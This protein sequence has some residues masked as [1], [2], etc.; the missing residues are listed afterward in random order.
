MKTK[1]CRRRHRHIRHQWQ[2]LRL[3]GDYF[4]VLTQRLLGGKITGNNEVGD[5]EHH[6]LETII[7]VKGC[8]SPGFFRVF[9]IQMENLKAISGTFPFNYCLYALWYYCS[10]QRKKVT[11]RYR[12]KWQ[13]ELSRKSR[14]EKDLDR[15]LAQKTHIVYLV[16]LAVIEALAR[17]H[18][19]LKSSLRCGQSHHIVRLNKKTVEPLF[20]ETAI[21]LEQLQLSPDLFAVAQLQI[22]R[23]FRWFNTSFTVKLLLRRDHLS[24]VLALLEQRNRIVAN[25]ISA[26]DTP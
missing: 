25:T 9:L 20:D 7:E 5:I 11:R 26:N 18:N 24:N 6:P 3:V 15:F 13:R 19:G 16:D 22:S 8:A 17:N 4:T 1:S 23:R 10:W 12:K 14:K 21:V 2:R